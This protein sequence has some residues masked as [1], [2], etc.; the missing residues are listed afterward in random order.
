VHLSHFSQLSSNAGALAAGVATSDRL[1]PA[2]LSIPSFIMSYFKLKS[3]NGDN[4]C[5][6]GVFYSA[7][8]EQKAVR[9]FVIDPIK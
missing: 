1:F 4:F 8:S 7:Y 6:A 5:F 2:V 3:E 9:G